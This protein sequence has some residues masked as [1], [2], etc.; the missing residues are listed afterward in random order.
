M[1]E[2]LVCDLDDCLIKTDALY[3]LW[4]SLLKKG[5]SFFS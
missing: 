5:L 4:L 2:Y 1:P 3:E